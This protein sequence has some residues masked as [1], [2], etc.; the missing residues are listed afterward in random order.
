MPVVEC[1]V[2]LEVRSIS[3]HSPALFSLSRGLRPESP[4][5]TVAYPMA[6]GSSLDRTKQSHFVMY[7]C[8]LFRPPRTQ[9]QSG[10]GVPGLVC[11]CPGS[12][13]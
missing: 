6:R 5:K 10:D 2:P 9:G 7:V 3:A 4:L 11:H 1:R 8:T 13:W 12:T